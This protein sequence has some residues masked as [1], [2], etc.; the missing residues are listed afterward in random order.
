MRRRSPKRASEQAQSDPVRT[1]LAEAMAPLVAGAEHAKGLLLESICRAGIAVM[2]ETFG[3]EAAALAGEKHRRRPDRD[4]NHW[5]QTTT[6]MTLGGR[7]VGVRRPRVRGR[8]GRELAL[9]SVEMFKSDDPLR[10]RVVEQILLGVCT[11]KYKGS[12]EELDT[13]LKTRAT[14]RSAVSRRFV[15]ETREKVQAQLSRPLDT[16]EG[17]VLLIDGIVVDQ[18]SLVVAL[19]S[20]SDGRQARSRAAP[21][22]D[23]ERHVVHRAS[24]GPA[25]TRD[26]DPAA[27]AVRCRRRR[28]NP[29]S[30]ARRLRRQRVDPALSAAQDAKRRGVP[31]SRVRRVRVEDH[32]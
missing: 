26:E 9:P 29:Q 31:T 7:R 6:E 32:A 30:P 3:R 14:S 10:R 11:R 8:D 22:L 2:L 17:V 4:A 28:R 19:R 18:K 24:A 23:G 13:N 21:G 1:V 27:P 12:L 16:L 5:G 20:G 25:A 15:A